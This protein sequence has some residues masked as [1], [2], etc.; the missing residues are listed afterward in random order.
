MENKELLFTEIVKNFECRD[1]FDWIDD[2]IIEE[3]KDELLET[4][5]KYFK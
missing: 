1:L 3:I 2:D 5:E 4:I